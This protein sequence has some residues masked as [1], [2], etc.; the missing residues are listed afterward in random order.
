M[1]HEPHHV[2]PAVAYP[3]DIRKRAVRIGRGIF[4]PVRRRITK[5]NLLV[6]LQFAEGRFITKIIPVAMRDRHLQHLAGLGRGSEWS[7]RSFYA[8]VNL[9]AHK[10]HPG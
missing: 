7:I 3:S 2:A 1:R 8:D 4:A 9:L 6:A 10:P 5:Y